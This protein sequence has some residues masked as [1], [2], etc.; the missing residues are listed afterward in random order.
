MKSRAGC[1]IFIGK[2]L[3][4]IV[5][6]SSIEAECLRFAMIGVFLVDGLEFNRRT[7]TEDNVPRA[8]GDSTCQ[9]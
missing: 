6:V 3:N 5:G 7:G 9:Q 2:R 4:A 1:R 8:S